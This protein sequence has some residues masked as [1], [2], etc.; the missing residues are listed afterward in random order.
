M[1]EDQAS[2]SHVSL[3]VPNDLIAA[4]DKLAT[5]LERPRSWVMLRALRQYLEDE[6]EGAEIFED[7]ES[8]AELDRG[9]IVSSEEMQRRVEE[10]ITSAR[11]R[12]PQK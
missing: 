11:A 6:G 8:L 3:R 2:S 1:P 12:A 5:A 7:L 9:E 10:I 4:Y